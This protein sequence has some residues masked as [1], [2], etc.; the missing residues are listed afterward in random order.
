MYVI[1][2]KKAKSVVFLWD[3]PFA[4]LLFLVFFSV[5]ARLPFCCT[6]ELELLSKTFFIQSSICPLVHLVFVIHHS[7]V[8]KRLLSRLEN[9]S[10]IPVSDTCHKELIISVQ[11]KKF[12]HSSAIKKQ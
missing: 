10:S 12:Q 7:S 11:E 6:F 5:E 4:H 8:V 1:L 2:T 9:P 3:L